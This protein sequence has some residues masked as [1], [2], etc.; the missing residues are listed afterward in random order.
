MCVNFFSV[1]TSDSSYSILLPVCI[2]F[3][4]TTL[5]SILLLIV[6]FLLFFSI[7]GSKQ[8]LL[9]GCSLSA[10]R[11]ASKH[12]C[13]KKFRLT[14]LWTFS[15]TSQQQSE[16]QTVAYESGFLTLSLIL[17]FAPQFSIFNAGENGELRSRRD[18]EIHSPH[19]PISLGV[20]SKK[21]GSFGLL[22]LILRSFWTGAYFRENDFPLFFLSK[23]WSKPVPISMLFWTGAYLSRKRFLGTG[24]Y[25]AVE[26]SLFVPWWGE[27]LG[28]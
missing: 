1:V 23:Q 20:Y 22:V 6:F 24:A 25:S 19:L 8:A 5:H 27:F 21:R 4:C 7:F 3:Y 13:W 9:R 28:F 17:I 15:N 12:L 10:N 11:A 16:R 18:T 2:G 26:K 14:A